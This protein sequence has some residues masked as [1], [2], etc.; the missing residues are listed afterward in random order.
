MPY[1]DVLIG[2]EIS[3]YGYT[4]QENDFES[5]FMD[6]GARPYYP[7]FNKWFNPDPIIADIYDPQNLN[8]YAYVLNNPYKYV[9]PTVNIVDTVLD[10]CFIG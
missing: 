8:R 10:V 5:G 2:D 3:R 1:G 7:L 6:Y 4:G 9:D